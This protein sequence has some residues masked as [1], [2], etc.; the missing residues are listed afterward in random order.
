MRN[1]SIYIVISISLYLSPGHTN[2]LSID[3]FVAA[4]DAFPGDCSDS[5]FLQAYVG[6][7]LD[8]VAM[9]DEETEYLDR[10]Y[11]R[12]PSDF[13]DTRKIIT[14][15]VS[16]QDQY[17]EK[18]AMLVVIRYLEEMGGCSIDGQLN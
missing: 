5:P 15:M 17:S 11:C 10:I 7:A 6:G 16:K 1:A 13:F 2:A 3:D 4:C 18:N 8:L 9:L 12:S 14:Y